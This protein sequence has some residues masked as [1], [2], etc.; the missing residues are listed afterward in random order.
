LLVLSP[1]AM[2]RLKNLHVSYVLHIYEVTTI[3]I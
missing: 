1:L 3:M 2:N